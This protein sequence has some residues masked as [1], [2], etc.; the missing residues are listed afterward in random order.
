MSDRSLSK[1]TRRELL[2]RFGTL[3]LAHPAMGTLGLNL[4]AMSQASAAS[5]G[6]GYKALVCI[7]LYG[8]NDAYNTVLATDTP[9]WQAYMAARSD[10][11]LAPPGAAA[12]KTMDAPFNARLGGAIALPHDSQGRGLA[13]HPCLREVAGLYGQNRLAILS[14]VGTL[15]GPL[16]K[17]QYAIPSVP[18]PAKLH[19]HND[20]QS[21]WQAMS[22]EGATSGWGGRM[23]DMMLSGNGHPMFSTISVSGNAVWLSGKQTRAY[24]LDHSGAIRAGGE[25]STLFGS[26]EARQRLLSVMRTAREDRILSREYAGVADRS[27]DA[28]RELVTA[29]PSAI[30]G[31]WGSPDTKPGEVDKLLMYRDPETGSMAAN[32]LAQQLQAVSRMIAA[33]QSLGMNRQ[34]FFVSL[35]GFDTHSGQGVRQALG[36]AKLSHGMA[37]FDAVMRAMGTDQNVT[38]FTASDFGRNFASNGDGCDH[39]WGGHHFV[40]GGA[41]RGGLPYGR[42]PTYGT[43][44]GV[45]G[46]NSPDQLAGGTLLPA[47]STDAYAATLG[48]WFGLSDTDLTGLFPNLNRWNASARNLGFMA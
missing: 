8:G 21:T 38:A 27:I 19:S 43:S 29:M 34:V 3:G 44:D 46:F 1:T 26:A 28:Q 41:V 15:V 7:F 17:A 42:F 48:R 11:A 37:Y 4:A 20:Q 35:G 40:M 47:I 33:R 25:G 14:N 6:G 39:G 32:P 45:G 22:P 36:L 16:S 10:I 31:P 23:V 12:V 2:R 30:A 13:V 9:S 24:Q 5:D 18:R